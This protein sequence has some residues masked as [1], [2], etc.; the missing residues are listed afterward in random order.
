MATEFWNTHVKILIDYLENQNMIISDIYMA[1]LECMKA[2]IKSRVKKKK[3]FI[4]QD[5]SPCC[6]SIASVEKCINCTSSCFRTESVPSDYVLFIN[7]KNTG[8]LEREMAPIKG[9]SP[10]LKYI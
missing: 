10:K 2:E 8:T 1:L 3:R 4:R 6:R 9:S 5:N 7:L